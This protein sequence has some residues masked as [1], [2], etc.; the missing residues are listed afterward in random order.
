MPSPLPFSTGRVA[1]FGPVSLPVRNP[2]SRDVFVQDLPKNIRTVGEISEDFCPGQIGRRA[3]VIDAILQAFPEADVSDPT[4][5]RLIK[6]NVY[7]IEVS[8]GDTEDLDFFAFHVSGEIEADQLI[9]RIL[10]TLCLRAI[11]PSTDSG[12]F[13]FV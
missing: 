5:V 10:E 3:T 13:Q 4:W 6:P 9:S 2:M 11:D 8:L 1:T 7:Y 12:L